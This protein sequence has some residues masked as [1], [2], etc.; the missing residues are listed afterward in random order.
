M[1]PSGPPPEVPMMLASLCMPVRLVE[2]LD[3][4]AYRSGAR[5]SDVMR[6][7]L[8]RFVAEQTAPVPRDEAEHAV[9]LRRIVAKAQGTTGDA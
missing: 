1:N 4:F 6:E 8:T 5:P 9:V 3:E 2:Q 7:A